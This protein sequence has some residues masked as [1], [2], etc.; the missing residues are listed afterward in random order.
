MIQ[1]SSCGALSHFLAIRSVGRC[2]EPR[3]ASWSKNGT[4]GPRLPANLKPGARR[5]F[6]MQ[7]SVFG[8]GYVGCVTAACLAKAG[9]EVVGVDVNPDKVSMVNAGL[10]PLVEPGLGD[11]LKEV[12]GK[13][14]LRATTSCQEAVDHSELAMICV[15]T[16]SRSN[17]QL[18]VEH[19]ERIGQ[20]IGQALRGGREAFTIVLRSTVLPG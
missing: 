3:V 8:L 15:G 20:E 16:P 11:L 18:N 1:P 19:I 4:R 7:V 2:W 6:M 5:S 17:G 10:S 13:G 12:V 14:R 9:H